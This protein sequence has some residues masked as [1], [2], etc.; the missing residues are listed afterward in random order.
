MVA[1]CGTGTTRS[2]TEVMRLGARRTLVVVSTLEL[3]AQTVHAYRELLPAEAL[4]AGGVLGSDQ[5]ITAGT[6]S[7]CMPRP[8]L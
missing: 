6:R 3:L 7:T 8:L 2:G 4:G 5:T 1:A